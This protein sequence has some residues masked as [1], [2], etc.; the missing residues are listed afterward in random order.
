[1]AGIAFMSLAAFG[2][3]DQSGQQRFTGQR[4]YILATEENSD[5]GADF[6]VVRERPSVVFEYP[7]DF[8]PPRPK[9]GGNC[10]YRASEVEFDGWIH[11]ATNRA[12]ITRI[13]VVGRYPP[14]NIIP[15][16]S[17]PALNC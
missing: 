6:I 10:L 13:R 12:T 8:K 15:M 11:R 2:C 1:M 5:H 3:A 4:A 14:E 7:A 17:P 16:P 9:P